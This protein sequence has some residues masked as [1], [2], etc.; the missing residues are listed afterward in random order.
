MMKT[1]LYT[2]YRKTNKEKKT[3]QIWYG[4]YDFIGPLRT[5][6]LAKIVP[7]KLM[8]GLLPNLS[9]LMVGSISVTSGDLVHFPVSIKGMHNH[10]MYKKNHTK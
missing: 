2:Y 4:K 9:S 3:A 1:C 5:R 7:T 8:V 6:I 10:N